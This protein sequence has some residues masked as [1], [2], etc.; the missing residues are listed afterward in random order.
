MEALFSLYSITSF[1]NSKIDMKVREK[2][3]SFLLFTNSKSETH[4]RNFFDRFVKAASRE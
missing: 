4:L 1:I 2:P 3:F